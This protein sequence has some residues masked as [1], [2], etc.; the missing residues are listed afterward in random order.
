MSKTFDELV[1]FFPEMAKAV[2][3]FSSEAVQQQAFATLLAT[4]DSDYQHFPSGE[5]NKNEL[6][7]EKQK[8]G[9]RRGKVAVKATKASSKDGKT[10]TT[11]TPKLVTNLNLRPT[12]KKA[13]RDFVSDKKPS[14]NQAR[15]AVILYYLQKTLALKNISQDHIYTAFK[16]LGT[17]VPLNISTA[18]MVTRIRK[19]WI[20]TSNTDDLKLT[21]GGEN[22]VEHDLP[23]S[24]TKK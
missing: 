7:K 12:G 23:I 4:L 21:I 20:N 2:N 19:G 24:A 9:R 10:R 17:K 3:S 8:L 14:D 5:E 11:D 1:K 16:E 18:L 6:K 13:L 22:F 15:F